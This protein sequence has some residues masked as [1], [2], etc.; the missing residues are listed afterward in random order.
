MLCG[1]I[2]LELVDIE[3]NEGVVSEGVEREVHEGAYMLTH[4]LN[5]EDS[6]DGR[7][8][9]DYFDELHEE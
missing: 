4:A 8:D 7:E 9:E 1:W 2:A 6:E 5:D 3:V